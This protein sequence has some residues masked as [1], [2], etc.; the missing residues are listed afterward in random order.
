MNKYF[1]GLFVSE[2]I[3][4]E[5]KGIVIV[6]HGI[7]EH[8]FYYLYTKDVL[9]KNGYSVVL[10]DLRGHGQSKGSR[11][12]IKNFKVYVEDLNNLVK[13]YKNL[14]K[15]N[16]LLIGHSLGALITGLYTCFYSDITS[17]VLS[18]CNFQTPKELLFLRK[19]PKFI[20][21]LKKIKTNFNDTNLQKNPVTTYDPY[22]LKSFRLS[23]VKETIFL[24]NSYYNAH[25]N[26]IKTPSLFLQG[27]LDTI[28]NSKLT[29]DSFNSL[30]VD[31]K[32]Y[33]EYSDS[34]HNLFNDE[35]KNQVI[36]D[37]ITWF[38]SF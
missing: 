6:T 32:K 9:V 17:C 29:I 19:I 16:V 10:Y 25:K 35:Q 36:A 31:N 23:L 20:L 7:A 3:V 5:Q 15:T 11:G 27:S 21:N 14:Y 2:Y 8:S 4:K 22:N 26:Q 24:G 28:I 37:C 38:N 1:N 13:Y 12:Y 30:S 18:A 34:R 33:I